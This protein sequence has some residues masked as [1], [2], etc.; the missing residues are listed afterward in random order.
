MPIRI[1]RAD[2]LVRKPWKNG[3]GTT[4]DVAVHPEGAG[5]DAF[6]WRLSIADVGVDGPFSIFP[7]IDRTLI[8]MTGAGIEL[9]GEQGSQRLDAASPMLAFAGDVA[10]TGRLIN[11]PIRD[12]NV[13]TR[14]DAYTHEVTRQG[15]GSV[16]TATG[17]T[18]WTICFA[19]REPCML[20]AGG[21]D[22][23]LG[24][25]DLAVMPDPM[26]AVAV[27]GPVLWVKIVKRG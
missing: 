25:F 3:G 14:R 12:F 27:D 22:Y 15:P 16:A 10:I 7:G 21:A 5:L 8:V 6:D 17:S 2:S 1:V 11:G 20:S 19:D 9:F 26:P 13:M 18:D 23:R 24:L 4:S